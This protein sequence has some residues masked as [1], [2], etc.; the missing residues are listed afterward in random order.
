VQLLR[1]RGSKVVWVCT[2]SPYEDDAQLT[3]AKWGADLVVLNDPTNIDRYHAAGIPAVYVPHSYDPAIHMP[4]PVRP[5]YESDVCI[6][7]TGYPSRVQWLGQMDWTG[8]DLALCGMWKTLEGHRLARHVRGV[9]TGPDDPDRL[10]TC[11]DNRETVLWYQSTAASLNLYRREAERP[12]LSAGY[13]MGP[14]EIELA[15]CGTF[16]VTEPRG[17][18][19]ERFPFIPKIESPQEAEEVLRW[20]LAHDDERALIARLAREAVQGWTFEA[21]TAEVLR[22]LDRAPVSV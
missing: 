14:R 2:E 6:V 11:I 7:G 10:E 4:G 5:E 22:T 21:R 3:R 8:I 16:Y 20:Y 1:A 19:V 12:E 17:E 18:N 13:A 9:T 15:A